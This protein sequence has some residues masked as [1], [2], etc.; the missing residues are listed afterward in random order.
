MHAWKGEVMELL[1]S[2]IQICGVLLA[3]AFWYH[4]VYHLVGFFARPVR[5][6]KEAPHRF[7]ILIS[8]RNEEHVI[9]DLFE[10]IRSQ[11]YP[12]DLVRIFVVADNCT[13][14]TAEVARRYGAEVVERFDSIRVGKGYALDTLVSHIYRTGMNEGI[15]AYLVFDADNILAEDYLQKM[16]DCFAAGEPA[17]TSYR[18]SKN[19]GDNWLSAGYSYG[20]IHDARFLNNTR[21]VLGHAAAI[22]GTGYLLDSEI[23]DR[24]RGWPFHGLTEDTELTCW[25]IIHGYHIAYCHDAVFYDEQ[26]VHFKQGWRQRMRWTKGSFSAFRE[27]RGRLL[28]RAVTHLDWS[29]W[30]ILVMNSPM[31]VL[32][33]AIFGL[34][35]LSWLI[36]ALHPDIL[37]WTYFENFL[38]SMLSYIF[39]FTGLGA[40]TMLKEWKRLPASSAVK[41]FG[42]LAYGLFMLFYPAIYL[43][44]LFKEVTWKPIVHQ[45]AKGIQTI[46]RD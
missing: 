41:I 31:Q 44:S 25:L 9:T 34:S 4:S 46:N 1:D 30:D 37:A 26:P 33:V 13:D 28:K 6:G 16:N 21:H 11:N 15:D 7:G 43:V 20:F 22:S 36:T 24:F 42:T 27:Y 3:L 38:A 23:L 40:L 2:I 17:V 19:M 10:S 5:Y 45:D 32:M 14:G 39:M 35:F 29:A 8:A 12:A 18:N